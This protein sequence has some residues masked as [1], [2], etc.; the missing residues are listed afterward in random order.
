MVPEAS[1]EDISKYYQYKFILGLI[2]IGKE[3]KKKEKNEKVERGVRKSN[4]KLFSRGEKDT[5][6][7]VKNISES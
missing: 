3:K 1:K 7:P 6:L 2:K 5:E 4:L